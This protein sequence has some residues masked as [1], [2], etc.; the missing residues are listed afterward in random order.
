MRTIRKIAFCLLA[1][2]ILASCGKKDDYIPRHD[3]AVLLA[4]LYMEDGYIESRPELRAQTD[5]LFIYKPIIES[6][7]YT[8]DRYYSTLNHYISDF[9]EWTAL[10]ND[11]KSI[12]GERKKTVDP[13]ADAYMMAMGLGSGSIFGR[14]LAKGLSDTASF[15]PHHFYQDGTDGLGAGPVISPVIPSRVPRDARADIEAAMKGAVQE[16]P[17][18]NTELMNS[19]NEKDTLEIPDY[20]RRKSH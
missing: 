14:R 9:G 1:A 12:L 19:D 2:L 6:H 17:S 20:L 10:L 16:S 4:D 5:S 13:A 18:S 8:M 11:V 3:F 7:G 15:K